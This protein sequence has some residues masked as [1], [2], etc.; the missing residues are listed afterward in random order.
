MINIHLVYVL[1]EKYR[2]F[3]DL[4]SGHK[5]LREVS[6][7]E[8]LEEAREKMPSVIYKRAHHVITE[9]KRA[10]AGA[11]ALN[12]NDYEAFGRLM[13]ES[14]ESLRNDF[15]VSCDELDQLVDLTRSVDGVYGSRM[16][17]AGFGK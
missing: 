6:T 15:E 14:H 16:T 7:I 2:Y 1:I 17:G 12:N 5:N 8:E 10:E 4:V 3:I 9:I 11:K 13:Y